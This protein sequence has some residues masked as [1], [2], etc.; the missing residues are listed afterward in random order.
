LQARRDEVAAAGENIRE[1]VGKHSGLAR[2]DVLRDE[3]ASAVTFYKSVSASLTCTLTDV[4]TRRDELAAVGD[5]F[6]PT[7]G[8]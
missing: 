4:L 5:T 1:V 3:A 8:R 2:I 6:L 7:P